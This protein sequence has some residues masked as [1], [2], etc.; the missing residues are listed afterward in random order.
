MTGRQQD[1]GDDRLRAQ[2]R[3]RMM[4]Q[5]LK[6][7]HRE[8]PHLLAPV[9]SLNTRKRIRV[10]RLPSDANP[11]CEDRQLADEYELLN[12]NKVC[13]LGGRSSAQA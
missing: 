10:P 12:L 8:R 11:F 2:Q 9:A 3:E 6:Q 7:F 5:E 13:V 1:D 4:L